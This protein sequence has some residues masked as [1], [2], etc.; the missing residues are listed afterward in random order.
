MRPSEFFRA[1]L[2]VLC[3]FSLAGC[4][5]ARP[6]DVSPPAPY[7]RGQLVLPDGTPLTDGNF[8]VL[9]R[10]ASYILIGEN[11][12][13]LLHHEVQ[14]RLL[15]VLAEAGHR[16]LLG[17]EMVDAS[18]QKALDSFNSGAVDVEGLPKALA[19]GDTWGFDFNL[20]RTVFDAAR[21]HSVPVYGLNVPRNVIAAVRGKGLEKLGAKEKKWLPARVVAPPEEQV[22]ELRQVFAMHAGM[23]SPAAS[24]GEPSVAPSAVSADARRPSFERFLLIQSLWDSAM[25]QKAVEVRKK[26]GRPMV[27]LAGNGHVERGFGIAHRLRQLDPEGR[28]L[29]ISPFSCG[30][31]PLQGAEVFYYAPARPRLGLVLRPESEGLVV[32]EVLEGSR[33]REAGV[34]ANDRI[35]TA[36]GEPVRSR[37]D[38]HAA[39]MRA[40]GSAFLDLEIERADKRM[41]IRVPVAPAS[42]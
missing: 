20:Y 27:I 4:F 11:H 1:A 16:P 7:A 19:W 23:R 31:L 21:A 40:S 36:G 18:R 39:A 30:A 12:D 38:M 35:L 5:S 15:A 29:L 33:A 3:C 17:L 28:I 9:A 24:R 13:N 22:E 25:A 34:R 41:R 6:E 26:F 8:A 37:A 14:A 2:A 32:T 42:N 10:G